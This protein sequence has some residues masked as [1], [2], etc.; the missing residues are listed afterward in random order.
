MSKHWLIV[1][2]VAGLFAC[3][4]GEERKAEYLEKASTLLAQSEY[5]KARLEV[6]NALQIDPKDANA[7]YRLGEIEEQLQNW[8]NAAA[9]YQ[10]VVEMDSANNDA[11]LRLGRLYLMGS[12]PER[13]EPLLQEVAKTDP[14]NVNAMVLRAALAAHQGDTAS[15]EKGAHAALKKD[16][17][18]VDAAIL[19]ASLEVRKGRPDEA[20]RLLTAAVAQHPKSTGLRAVL[21]GVYAQQGKVDQGAAQLKEIV[22]L[23]PHIASHRTHVAQYY[24]ANK[25]LNEAEQVLREG[26]KQP[27]L[28][29]DMQLA[30][31]NFLAAQRSREQAAQALAQF[32]KEAPEDYSLKFRL[33]ELQL[34]MG[35]PDEA[36]AEYEGIIAAA[37]DKPDGLKARTQLARQLIAQGQS[38][39]AK[40]LVTEVLTVNARDNDALML[41]ASFAMAQGDAAAA[42]NDLR[43]I[44][45]DQPASVPVLRELSRAHL[46]KGEP[47][48]ALEALQ[49]AVEAAPRDAETRVAFAR[50]LAEQGKKDKAREQLE[51]VLK[52]EPKQMS[53]LETLFQLYMIEKDYAQ[54]AQVAQRTK[55]IQPGRGEYYAGLVFQAQKKY[56]DAVAQFEMALKSVPGA[57]EPLTA[58]TKSLLAQNQP[59]LAEQRLRQ[60]IARDKENVIA[61]NLLGEVLLMQKKY[62]PAVVALRDAQRLNPRLVTPY[63]N[64]AAAHVGMGDR[65]AALA[66]LRE[67]ISATKSDPGLVFALAN[68]QENQGQADQAI[69]LYEKALQAR[70]NEPL[71]MNNLAMML[72]SYRSDEANLNR[73]IELG[74]RLK[75]RNNPA[76]LD[77][78]GW[79]YYQ[80]GDM[81]AAAPV[82][83][84]ASRQAPNSPLL[85][86][87]LGMV[88]YQKGDH[89]AARRHLER[90]TKTANYR[91]A[92][93]AKAT[94]AK[95]AS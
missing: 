36:R 51:L 2:L 54:A 79:A 68:Y 19:T 56:T 22:A 25:R 12:A 65:E 37:G 70:P 11:R 58:L 49:K 47:D 32:S 73:A 38:D 24:V 71:F 40:Q 66:T 55:E 9:I 78:L 26:L 94:L 90:A 53:A 76:Y 34:L 69:A 77:T 17:A 8:R 84:A 87:H 6:K 74:E 33:A 67:G 88:Y 3:S 1:I 23:E 13:V 60:E 82:L 28:K 59:L 89:A 21:A 29:K 31:V 46:M 92:D 45:R 72:V 50:F 75:D 18:N 20:I 86:Y 95:L 44:L 30:L 14:D 63:R 52:A 64:L 85:N 41:R 10:K 62:E 16:P 80:R 48:L 4:S 61:Q 57:T 7:W 91:G 5:D 39:R 43:A 35:K 93:E 83:E 27:A 42:V 15:A 81:A